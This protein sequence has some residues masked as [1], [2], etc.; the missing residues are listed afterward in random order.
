[1]NSETKNAASKSP[2]R[3]AAK[4]DRAAEIPSFPHKR[5]SSASDAAAWRDAIVARNREVIAAIGDL[6]P[7]LR[8]PKRQRQANSIASGRYWQNFRLLEHS[9]EARRQRHCAVFKSLPAGK[10][11]EVWLKYA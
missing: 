5:G 9:A 8:S 4:I 6:R 3:L 11:A 1:M 2:K 10:I 7:R